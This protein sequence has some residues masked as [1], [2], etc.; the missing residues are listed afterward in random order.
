MN[1]VI[2]DIR[3][4]QSSLRDLDPELIKDLQPVSSFCDGLD[5]FVDQDRP[6]R[7]RIKAYCANV[8]QRLRA[9]ALYASGRTYKQYIE[10]QLLNH[11]AKGLYAWTKDAAPVLESGLWK[12]QIGV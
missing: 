10:D 2:N 3:L 9:K 11:H 5:C 4:K 7:N 6:E 12:W 1:R 8:L